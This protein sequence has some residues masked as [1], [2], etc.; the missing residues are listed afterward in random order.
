MPELNRVLAE[1]LGL[2][3]GLLSAA[4]VLLL[5]V[6]LAGW[7]RLAR[8]V[9]AYRQLT[10]GESGGSLDDV[11]AANVTRVE[12]VRR[13]I[14]ELMGVHD[15]LEQRS[16]GSLQ[17]VGLVRFNPFEDT[18]SDQSFAIALLDGR[19]DGIVI[20]SLHGRTNTRVF[21]KPVANGGST[22]NLS[23]EETQ[24]IRLAVEGTDRTG[25]A[26]AR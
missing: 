20:S 14:D 17:H 5:L 24:A 11:L 16:R 10:R 6:V 15:V 4:V 25:P 22:H 9:R 3:V 1:N 19:R 13:R 7:M 8:A 18:G 12:E 21:A 2:V 23:E 26:S